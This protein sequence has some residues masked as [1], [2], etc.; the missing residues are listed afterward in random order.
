MD[1]T[2]RPQ[3]DKE[4]K[5]LKQLMSILKLFAGDLENLSSNL[6]TTLKLEKEGFEAVRGSK[7]RTS[8]PRGTDRQSSQLDTPD[9][10]CNLDENSKKNNLNR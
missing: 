1:D 9:V 7:P 3:L 4:L 2:R 8:I 5:E 10:S 6:G